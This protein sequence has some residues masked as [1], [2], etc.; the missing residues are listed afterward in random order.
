MSLST[1][2]VIALRHVAFED[3]GLIAP[4]LAAAGW[5]VSYRDAALD[6]LSDPALQEAG[7]LVV[8]GGPIGVYEGDI[9]PFLGP[10]IAAVEK[11]IRGG[12]PILGICL[13]AQAM[14]AALGARVYFGGT[15]EIGFG[16]VTLTEAGAKSAL[17]PLAA[18]EAAVLHWH[19]DTFDLPQGAVRLASNDIYPNQAFSFG[20][21]ALALQFHLEADPRR[22]ERWLVGH[23]VELA[24]AGI[25]IPA[26]RA[27]T[28]GR[29]T[30]Y[31]SQAAAV[32]GRWLQEI[33]G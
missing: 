8:L 10:E 32:F 1:R 29:A 9:Y 5:T 12:R 28:A 16:P 21:N 20:S 7:L 23:A 6:D 27:G 11:R 14:A 4:L 25:D 13:G 24:K 18:P 17:A 26:L 2:T 19:G 15:K 31:A 3:L 30:H 33:G 22:L